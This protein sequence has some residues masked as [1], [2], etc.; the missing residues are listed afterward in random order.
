M[1]FLFLDFTPV[2]GCSIFRSWIGL[3]CHVTIT[4]CQMLANT[5]NYDLQNVECQSLIPSCKISSK[6]PGFAK[7]TIMNLSDVWNRRLCLQQPASA[8][9]L[10]HGC[11][12]VL[13]DSQGCELFHFVSFRS[14]VTMDGNPAFT[15]H[16]TVHAVSA[17]INLKRMLFLL[18]H[19]IWCLGNHLIFDGLTCFMLKWIWC[20]S[21]GNY[22]DF[23]L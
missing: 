7:R 15:V 3:E 12:T 5:S 19:Q 22:D 21:E 14:C 4:K 8:C 2:P 1:L 20:G 17:A 13:S 18:R 6:S 11:V 16:A 10:T 9:G 23:Y